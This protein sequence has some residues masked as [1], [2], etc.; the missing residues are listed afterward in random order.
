MSRA[1]ESGLTITT[2]IFRSIKPINKAE[3]QI[4]I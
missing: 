3:F 4:S 1:N 2:G